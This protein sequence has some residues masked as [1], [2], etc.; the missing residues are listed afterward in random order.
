M[1]KHLILESAVAALEGAVDAGQ[2]KGLERTDREIVVECLMVCF[3]ASCV[4]YKGN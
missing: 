4:G 2:V 1:H 3:K